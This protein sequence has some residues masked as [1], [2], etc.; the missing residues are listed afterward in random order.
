M[1]V[2]QKKWPENA[3]SVSIT[4]FF[5]TGYQ[6]NSQKKINCI[7]MSEATISMVEF[8]SKIFRVFMI[9]IN[10]KIEKNAWLKH[11]SL[12]LISYSPAYSIHASYHS[13]S[14]RKQLQNHLP[15]PAN[16]APYRQNLGLTTSRRWQS[17]QSV[18]C[19][20]LKAQDKVR[21]LN[22]SLLLPHKNNRSLYSWWASGNEQFTK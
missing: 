1:K 7:C 11:I 6:G 22:S 3:Y 17:S 2:N 4:I 21:A 12:P 19:T 8:P 10:I 20:Q 14:Y 9:T 18:Q 5:I 16:K 15:T 13:K